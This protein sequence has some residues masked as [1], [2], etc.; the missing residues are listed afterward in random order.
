VN[1]FLGCLSQRE[2]IEQ[3][4]SKLIFLKLVTKEN[5]TVTDEGSI[6]GLS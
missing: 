2:V 3:S 6:A 5:T 1:L 4:I